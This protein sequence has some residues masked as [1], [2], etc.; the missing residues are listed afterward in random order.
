MS[1]VRKIASA[2]AVMITVIHGGVGSQCNPIDVSTDDTTSLRFNMGSTPSWAV[3][4]ARKVLSGEIPDS[5]PYR[6]EPICTSIRVGG[7]TVDTAKN[8]A[9][10]YY[11]GS[12]KLIK[13]ESGKYTLQC[14]T[15]DES[16]SCPYVE[17]TFDKS[18]TPPDSN[19]LGYEQKW[20]L[21]KSSRKT[22]L[23][24]D[25][26]KV[27]SDLP[28][29]SGRDRVFRKFCDH[30]SHEYERFA[31]WV[32]AQVPTKFA[33][34]EDDGTHVALGAEDGCRFD[35]IINAGKVVYHVVNQKT[36]DAGLQYFEGCSAPVFRWGQPFS[37]Q[38]NDVHRISLGG[39]DG[40]EIKCYTLHTSFNYTTKQDEL[41]ETHFSTYHGDNDFGGLRGEWVKQD[42]G[43]WVLETMSGPSPK[44]LDARVKD[45]AAI[46]ETLWAMKEWFYEHS[47]RRVFNMGGLFI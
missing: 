20:T 27:L 30:L 18:N 32:E 44:I 46:C 28:K 14:F 42:D 19:P 40:D 12:V 33:R 6:I 5:S 17:Y 47:E 3:E 45:A 21:F 39:A 9:D 24:A 37:I 23:D 36:A 2:S 31:E 29:I 26:T 43:S 4:K 10:E 25:T 1:Y 22:T 11:D 7:A 15:E 13:E 41:K 38:K 8:S 34:V 16:A 35:L